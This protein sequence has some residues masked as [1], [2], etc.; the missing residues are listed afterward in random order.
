MAAHDRE[1]GG[2]A[3]RVEVLAVGLGHGGSLLRCARPID[4]PLARTRHPTDAADERVRAVGD[5]IVVHSTSWRWDEGVVLTYIAL[6]SRIDG[7][8]DRSPIV[9]VHLAHAAATDPPAEVDLDE[10][11]EHALRH[12]AW[13]IRDDRAVAEAL[14]AEWRAALAQYEPE[15]FRAF[16]RES[17]QRTSL[18]P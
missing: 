5:A 3:T 14:S 9:R 7:R 16:D 18:I 11:V 2:P 6:M 10:V 8:L 12:M 1:T 17:R 4:V 15:P 13:L